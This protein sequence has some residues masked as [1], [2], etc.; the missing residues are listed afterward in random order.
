MHDLPSGE[1]KTVCF[2]DDQANTVTVWL[3][4]SDSSAVFTR[5]LIHPLYSTD[6]RFTSP[7][8]F[9]LFQ[10]LKNSLNGKNFDSLEDYKKSPGTVLCSKR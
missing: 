2:F 1:L 3:G 5:L 10:S 4:S 7:S 6:L 9:H 8:D